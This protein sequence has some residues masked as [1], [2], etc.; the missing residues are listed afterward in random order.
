MGERI[1]AV[2]KMLPPKPGRR[3]RLGY[4]SG[5]DLADLLGVSRTRIP[6]WEN[7]RG[8]P[9]PP[10]RE[11]L[12]ELSGGRF[13]PEDFER[14]SEPQPLPLIRGLREDVDA[15]TASLAAAE[16]SVALLTKRVSVL[17]E[18]AGDQPSR[19]LPTARSRKQAPKRA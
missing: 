1:L 18:K 17:E 9:D 5:D 11:R 6:V 16:K 10:Q 3:T 8:H 12:A 4:L 19:D 13:S 7:G 15:L 2:R 14:R